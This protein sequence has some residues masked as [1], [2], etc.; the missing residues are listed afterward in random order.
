MKC[1]CLSD[2]T[3]SFC[4]YKIDEVNVDLLANNVMENKD[5]Q[6]IFD[7]LSILSTQKISSNDSN[8]S[9]LYSYIRN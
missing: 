3:G 5:Q 8:L 4:Q 1:Q 2:Y 6:S 9:E 7:L